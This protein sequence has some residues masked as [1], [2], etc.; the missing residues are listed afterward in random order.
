MFVLKVDTLRPKK[1]T[2]SVWPQELPRP[3][4]YDID[5]GIT[6]ANRDVGTLT[7]VTDQEF[8]VRGKHS[9]QTQR[10]FPMILDHKFAR[11]VAVEFFRDF[12]QGIE[13]SSVVQEWERTE[14]TGLWMMAGRLAASVLVVGGVF[15]LITQGFA[16][17]SV[18]PI[19]SGSGLLGI[20]LVKDLVSR[21]STPK[22]GA[23][24]LS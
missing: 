8:R 18:L 19:I 12:L 16:V 4:T 14:G 11:A 15:Y 9:A 7:Q 24:R 3:F 22:D 21:V 20:P 17:Q 13:R 6:V 2:I 1:N 5:L 23:A 10:L